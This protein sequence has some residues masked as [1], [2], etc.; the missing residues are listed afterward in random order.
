MANFWGKIKTALQSINISPWRPAATSRQPDAIVINNVNVSPNRRDTQD[1]A[2][3]RNAHIQA[4]GPNQNRVRLYDLYDDLLVDGFLH[5]MLRKRT[6]AVTNRKLVFLDA[7][8]RR[9]PEVSTLAKKSYFRDLITEIMASLYWGHSLV[10]LHWPAANTAT[11]GWTKVV[12]RKHVKPRFGIVTQQQNDLAGIPYREAPFSATTIEVGDEESLGLLL[13]AAPYVIYK[14]GG[15][16]DWAEFAEVFGMPF[17]WASYNNEQ[18]RQVLETAL[19]EAGSAGYVV[20]PTDANI[21]FHHGSNGQGNDV[22]RFLRMACNEE[23]AITVLGNTMTTTEARNSGYA[24]SETHADGEAEL[25]AD[26]RAMVLSILNEK[27]NAYLSSLGYPVANG[28]WHWEEE[29]RTP[30][31]D[32]IDIDTKLMG[33]IPIASSYFYERYGVPAPTAADPPP[34]A[35]AEEDPADEADEEE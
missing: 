35:W 34:G 13:Q 20:A 29:D 17:R 21:Q 4:E 18:T 22:F 10:E 12:P 28:E 1:I 26:D 30:L 23:I 6:S 19:A 25:N 31:K 27:L 3:W 7:E 33:I 14:R 11:P 2:K 5:A 32:R 24:Q 16:G 15:F 9:V 8:G